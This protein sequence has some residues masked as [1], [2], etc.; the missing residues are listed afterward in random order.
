MASMIGEEFQDT[1][2]QGAAMAL[3][4]AGMAPRGGATRR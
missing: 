4:L 1:A 2:A 3:H